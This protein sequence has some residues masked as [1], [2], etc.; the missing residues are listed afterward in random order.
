MSIHHLV[1]TKLSGYEIYME[2]Y[3]NF[4][5]NKIEKRLI[6]SVPNCEECFWVF[7]LWVTIF[8][9]IVQYFQISAVYMTQEKGIL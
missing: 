9:C 1:L 5:G 2:Y 3:S 6:A 8:L 7:E 4:R